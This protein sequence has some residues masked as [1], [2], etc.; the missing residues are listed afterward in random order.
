MQKTF[1]LEQR[2]RHDLERRRL[3]EEIAETS[4]SAFRTR[5][6]SQQLELVSKMKGKDDD[7]GLDKL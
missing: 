4:H 5:L 3:T 6:F 1:L 7:K 2:R